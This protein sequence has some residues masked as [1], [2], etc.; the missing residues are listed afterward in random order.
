[1]SIF[2]I[3][4]ILT[5]IPHCLLNLRPINTLDN[6]FCNLII[7]YGDTKRCLALLFFKKNFLH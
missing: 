4:G 6:I 3:S 7:W 1:M 5:P 2:K